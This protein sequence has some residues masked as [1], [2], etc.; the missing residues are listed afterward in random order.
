PHHKDCNVIAGKMWL[1]GRAYAAQ[2]ERGA[3][4][5]GKSNVIYARVAAKLAASNLD[6]QLEGISE[7]SSVTMENLDRVLA[8][9]KHLVDLIREDS[10][11]NRTAFSAK[12]L[13]FHKPYAFFIFDSLANEKLRQKVPRR[14]FNIPQS[15]VAFDEAYAGFV[16]RCIEYRTRREKPMT[17][18]QLDQELLGYH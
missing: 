12:Y 18:R 15:C 6:E 17:P 9:H 2:I 3:G 14:R 10:K 5:P 4:E 11:L 7:V 1:I 13:H 8:V 16:L